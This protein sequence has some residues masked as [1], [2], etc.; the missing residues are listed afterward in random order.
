MKEESIKSSQQL[1]SRIQEEGMPALEEVY[2]IY[3]T[4]FLKFALRYG[5][6]E[7][8]CLD[9]YHDVMI[10]FYENVKEGKLTTLTSSLKTYLFSIGKYSLLNQL[11][12]KK[13]TTSTE[14][15]Y[16]EIEIA[17]DQYLE[18]IELTH[19]QQIIEKA[20]EQLG[21]KCRELLTLFY[22][23]GY[24]IKNIK[25]TMDYNTDNTVKA[26]KSRCMK[27]LKSILGETEIF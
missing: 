17:A 1:L 19:R 20:F 14:T 24:S 9:T 4:D 25:N 6:S 26:T 12:S 13:R 22:Y 7:S 11:K 8:D 18:K 23:H 10:S 2:R 27:S 5:L 15:I 3:R 16:P 21:K